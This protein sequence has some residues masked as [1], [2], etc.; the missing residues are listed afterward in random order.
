MTPK[1]NLPPCT[2]PKESHYDIDGENVACYEC[3]EIADPF[4]DN[5]GW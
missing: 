3:E 1:N 4:D 2:H 5:T